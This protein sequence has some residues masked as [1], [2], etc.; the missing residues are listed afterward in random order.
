MFVRD[1]LR[2]TNN[3]SQQVTYG[4][5]TSKYYLSSLNED[6]LEDLLAIGNANKSHAPV[7]CKWLRH[8][9]ATELVCREN[10]RAG[11][12]MQPGVLNPIEDWREWTD[13]DIASANKLLTGL[14]YSLRFEREAIDWLAIVMAAE[15]G[16]RLTGS[17]AKCSD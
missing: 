6:E 9:A 4:M 2:M 14:T 3:N 12:E 13:Q 11:R 7:F 8:A 1:K 15:V 10:R 16:Q 17:R 5:Q